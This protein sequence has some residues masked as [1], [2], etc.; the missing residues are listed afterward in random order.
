[1]NYRLVDHRRK[2]KKFAI[3]YGK[4]VIAQ[5]VILTLNW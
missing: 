1:M 2:Y 3:N 4:Y 5:V